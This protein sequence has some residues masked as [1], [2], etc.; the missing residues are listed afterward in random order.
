MP[1]H[2]YLLK[3]A[4]VGITLEQVWFLDWQHNCLH[5]VLFCV[6]QPTYISPLDLGDLDR[7][8]S[9]T[10]SVLLYLGES[11][12]QDLTCGLALGYFRQ[13]AFNFLECLSLEEFCDMCHIIFHVSSLQYPFYNSLTI[14]FLRKLD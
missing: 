6:C 12:H 11:L 1:S 10:F 13:D 3:M 14:S 9:E 5:Y 4:Y 8:L 2:L 7:F